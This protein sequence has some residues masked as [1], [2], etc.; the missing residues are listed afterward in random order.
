MSEP[1]D[2]ILETYLPKEARAE[3][4]FPVVTQIA[5][6]GIILL[7][8]LGISHAPKFIIGSNQ[9]DTQKTAESAPLFIAENTIQTVPVIE[10]MYIGAKSAYVYDVRAKRD[11]AI[12]AAHLLKPREAVAV[13]VAAGDDVGEAVAIHVGHEHLRAAGGRGGGK[14]ERVKIPH[15]IAR[16]RGG[17][18]PPTV[19]F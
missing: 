7:A 3:K 11:F 16:E 6:L 17:L 13:R 15:R 4:R 10:N 8:I 19:F 18:L 5:V 2:Y 12:S 14:R 1:D 9:N